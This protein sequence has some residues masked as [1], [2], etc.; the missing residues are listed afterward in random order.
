[1]TRT[2]THLQQTTTLF[3]RPTRYT[4]NIP[5][6]VKTYK[7]HRPSHLYLR[8]TTPSLSRVNT[9]QESTLPKTPTSAPTRSPYSS[10]TTSTSR[11]PFV[12]YSI[13]N[14]PTC[15]RLASRHPRR[16]STPYR[17]KKTLHTRYSPKSTISLS[18]AL[19]RCSLPNSASAH[20][21]SP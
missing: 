20:T 14:S 17:Y 5:L 21:P 12:P 16:D 19:F 4:S 8:R 9:S 7:A 3:L 18:P 13:T 10:P 6:R 11:P 2:F 1:L 15:R